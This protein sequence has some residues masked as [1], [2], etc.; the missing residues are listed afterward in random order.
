MNLVAII[1]YRTPNADTQEHEKMFKQALES[2]EIAA[3][4]IEVHCDIDLETL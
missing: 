1:H 2:V 4:I 3:D